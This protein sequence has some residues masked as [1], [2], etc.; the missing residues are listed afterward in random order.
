MIAQTAL[1]LA[2]SLQRPPMTMIEHTM[3]LMEPQ[4]YEAAIRSAMVP[5]GEIIRWYISRVDEENATAYAE[6]VIAPLAVAV[7][8]FPGLDDMENCR[9]TSQ[10][11]LEI[12]HSSHET[13]KH[14]TAGDL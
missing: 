5:H 8:R 2:F 14:Q 11:D 3:P 7:T 13:K 12:E 9:S 10:S 1:V 4:K 6:V